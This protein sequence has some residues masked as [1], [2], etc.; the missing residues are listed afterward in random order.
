ML[1]NSTELQHGTKLGRTL[2]H[3][4]EHEALSTRLY[5]VCAMA[6]LRVCLFVVSCWP[7]MFH[8]ATTGS[9]RRSPRD[10]T[11]SAR[12]RLACPRAGS[13]RAR[14][15]TATSSAQSATQ[16]TRRRHR[17]GRRAAAADRLAYT[18]YSFTCFCVCKDQSSLYYPRPFALPTLLQYFGATFAQDMTSPRP[19]LYMPYS[20]QYW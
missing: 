17:Q 11:L 2:C 12:W 3:Y 15:T 16:P 1:A 20:I 9:S 5:S 10:S 18:N 13:P 8:P 6:L 7:E 14:T 19:S 4:R